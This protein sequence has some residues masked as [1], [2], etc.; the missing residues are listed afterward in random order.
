MLQKGAICSADIEAVKQEAPDRFDFDYVIVDE[1]QD[2]PEAEVETLNIRSYMNQSS[3]A[4]QTELISSSEASG[5][6]G[7]QG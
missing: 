3:F 7:M 5:P 1:A 4:W 6:I 2:W